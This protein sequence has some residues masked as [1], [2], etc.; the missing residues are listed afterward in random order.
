MV[1]VIASASESTSGTYRAELHLTMP[2]DW[3]FLVTGSLPGGEMLRYQ[4]DL[5]RVRPD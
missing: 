3:V 1:P 5:P 4:I 2:G